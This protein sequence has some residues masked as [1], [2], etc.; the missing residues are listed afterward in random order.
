MR[1]KSIVYYTAEHKPLSLREIELQPDCENRVE[2]IF[3]ALNIAKD[4]DDLTE[5]LSRVMALPFKERGRTSKLITYEV[6]TP[7]GQ[8][9]YL[10]FTIIS[11]E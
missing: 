1:K 9:N 2:Y 4:F 8:I 7:D 3:Y 11:A 10:R 5:Q 6:E